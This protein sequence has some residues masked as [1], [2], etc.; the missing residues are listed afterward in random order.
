M[1]SVKVIG[2]IMAAFLLERIMANLLGHLF[3]YL[4]GGDKIDVRLT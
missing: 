3:G 2:K 1:N 4:M